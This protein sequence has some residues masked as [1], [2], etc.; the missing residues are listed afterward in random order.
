[1]HLST[2]KDTLATTVVGLNERSPFPIL[3]H[4]SNYLSNYLWNTIL[5]SNAFR[6]VHLTTPEQTVAT[7]WQTPPD[8]LVIRDK[9][10]ICYNYESI[11]LIKRSYFNDF[12]CLLIP[13]ETEYREN[14]IMKLPG[15]TDRCQKEIKFR[16]QM[17]HDLMNSDISI[18]AVVPIA[19]LSADEIRKHR[20]V[21]HLH[22]STEWKATKAKDVM[23][24][25]Y[26]EIVT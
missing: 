25:E 2:T 18:Q 24:G 23:R 5:W 14:W 9:G 4:L 11:I 3:I 8:T 10:I 22:F 13:A 19:I 21:F 15:G 20:E 12:L 17:L 26:M 7:C 1:M 6:H 16:R